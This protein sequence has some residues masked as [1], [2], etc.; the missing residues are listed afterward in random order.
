[1]IIEKVKGLKQSLWSYF[2]EKHHFILVNTLIWQS[3]EVDRGFLPL[4]L[5]LTLCSIL[6]TW[7][8]VWGPSSLLSL[9]LDCCCLGAW[10]WLTTDTDQVLLHDI[11]P[12]DRSYLQGYLGLRPYTDLIVLLTDLMSNFCKTSTVKFLWAAQN[13]SFMKFKTNRYFTL[14]SIL[15]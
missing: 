15:W 6:G 2:I 12:V 13:W 10:Y 1:M 3:L 7:W 4:T 14:H 9:F 11:T 5:L 8:I